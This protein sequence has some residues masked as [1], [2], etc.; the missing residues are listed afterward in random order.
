MNLKFLHDLKSS[1]SAIVDQ[2]SLLLD[3]LA[4][5]RHTTKFY[6]LWV[7]SFIAV[8][9]HPFHQILFKVWC[10]RIEP[11][12]K[13][14]NGFDVIT[15]NNN[16]LNEYSLTPGIWQAMSEVKKMMSVSIVAKH[17]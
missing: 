9:L 17:G 10:N 5:C 2:W 11:F 6:K 15:Q 3:R 8:N 7:I 14:A 13:A 1:N 4:A 12:M 16:N